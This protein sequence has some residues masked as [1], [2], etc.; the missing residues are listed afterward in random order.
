MAEKDNKSSFL[1][2]IFES[3]SYFFEE[4]LYSEGTISQN[5]KEK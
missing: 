4:N 1:E 2:P 5:F 3:Q